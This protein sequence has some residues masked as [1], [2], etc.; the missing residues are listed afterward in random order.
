MCAKAENVRCYHR[1]QEAAR[2]ALE[3]ARTA[4][5]EHACDDPPPGTAPP[6]RAELKPKRDAFSE[7]QPDPRA[8]PPLVTQT[9]L[10]ALSKAREAAAAEAATQHR[11]WWQMVLAVWPGWPEFW[12]QMRWVLVRQLLAMACSLALMYA[13]GMFGHKEAQDEAPAAAAGLSASSA[14]AH[15]P[16]GF[17]DL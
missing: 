13:A 12:K 11:S 3:A 15:N 8:P 1:K 9:T 16:R 17:E 10:N 2:N 7:I 14:A 4:I 5:L 6:S